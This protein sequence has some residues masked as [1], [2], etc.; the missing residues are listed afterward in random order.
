MMASPRN[1]STENG[2][3]PDPLLTFTPGADIVFLP[4]VFDPGPIT[5]TPGRPAA[6]RGRMKLR[7]NALRLILAVVFVGCAYPPPELAPANAGDERAS[8][9]WWH[10]RALIDAVLS[11]RVS[12]GARSGYV[13]LVAKD[14]RVVHGF[15]KG[16]RDIQ[17]QTPMS[18]ETHFRMASMTKPVTGVAAMILLEEGTISLDDP[19]SK[20]LPEYGEMLVAVDPTS[21]GEL[22]TVEQSPEMQ[23]RH[24][25]TFAS[26]I[27]G[28][29]RGESTSIARHNQEFGL[30]AGEGTLADRV[31]R[32]SNSILYEQPGTQWRYGAALDVMARVV[33]VAS[34]QPFDVFLRERIFEPLKMNDTHFPKNLPEGVPLATLYTQNENG[35]LVPSERS[36]FYAADWTPGGSGL[37]STAPDYMR[38]ALMLWN[39]GEYDGVRILMPQTVDRMTTPHLKNGVLQN[40]GIEGL[41]Y[42]LGVSVV[43][44]EDETIMPSHNGDYWWSGAHGTHFWISPETGVV[45]VVL[46]QNASGPHSGAPIA[47]YIV[48]GLAN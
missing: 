40:F 11:F 18:M 25:L 16:Y 37:V 35:D 13:A 31:E 9:L 34:G 29:G 38:F 47:P 45:I 7:Q 26:G 5:G 27:G 19:V 17:S 2:G 48:Q 12:T 20:Y 10:E 1:D 32:L 22:A 23:L 33:E 36:R 46:Q 41:G 21:D 15:T 39:R 42:G 3:S 4:D 24:L 43:V 14:G 44:D 6:T 28:G 30:Y 8:H